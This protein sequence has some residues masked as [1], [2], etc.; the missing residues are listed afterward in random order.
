[1]DKK[2]KGRIL[3]EALKLFSR[4]GYSGTSMSDIANQLN[5][6][7]GALYRHYS[8]KQA[9][10]DSIVEKMSQLDLERAK[11]YEMPEGTIEEMEEVYSLTSAANIITYTKEQFRYWTK[12]EFPSC[13]RRMLTLEQYRDE[14]M[15]KLYHNYIA[16]GPLQYMA[17]I[18]GAILGEEVDAMQTALDFYGPVFL[19][20]SVYDGMEDKE[21][22][23]KILDQHVD[24]F[25]DILKNKNTGDII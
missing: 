11:E 25:L 9:I 3:E 22:V 21:V 20:Y 18:F 5:I 13:F 23:L 4:N 14:N 10:F 7:K 15:A 17:D 6:T 24:H 19:L 1:M 16:A 8:S 2:T 12:E